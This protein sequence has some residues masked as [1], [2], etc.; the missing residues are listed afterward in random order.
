MLVFYVPSESGEK[1]TLG[2]SA[3]LSMTVFLMTIRES[4]PPT[5]KTPL[6]S[7]YLI[8]LSLARRIHVYRILCNCAIHLGLYYGVSICLVSFASAMAV[9]TLNIHHRGVRGNEVPQLV[10]QL[11]LGI[12]SR[13]V[14]LHFDASKNLVGSSCVGGGGAGGGRRNPLARHLREVAASVN[15]PSCIYVSELSESP[16]W[17]RK[18][19][20]RGLNPG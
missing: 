3:L 16:F 14:F 9:V 19:V 6:I 17:T 1:V 13:F 11:V 15:H 8:I 7:E 5:E 18:R 12:L 2:I 4:L 10:K 20:V